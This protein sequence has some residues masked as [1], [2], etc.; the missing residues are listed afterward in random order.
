MRV[1]YAIIFSILCIILTVCT[2][3]AMQQRRSKAIGGAVAFFVCSLLPPVT[4]NLIIV[5]TQNRYV[6]EVG[7][8]VY[9]LGM[10][11]MVYSLLRLTFSYCR[12]SWHN[13]TVKYIV[14][15]L[16]AIDVLQYALNPYL[17]Q[18]FDTEP[19]IVENETYYK[20]VPFTGQLYHRILDY[21]V[22][23]FVLGVFFIKMIRSI[24][25]NRERYSVIFLSLVVGGVWE[26][27]YI[28]SGTPIDRSMIGFVVIG[29][30]VYY[31]ALFYRPMRL[32][33]SMLANMT[34]EL[35]E[36]LYFFDNN[37]LC[38]WANRPGTELAAIS[39][40]DYS[41]A[42]VKLTELFGELDLEKNEWTSNKTL[43][44]DEETRYYV[45][46]KHA[47]PY[48]D[49]K[50]AGS[51]LSIRDNTE[52]HLT[53]Q[54]EM[55]NATHDSLT[56]LYTKDYF[57]KKTE[58]LLKSDNDTH[59]VAVY[60]NVNN[61]KLI[62]D[63][64][65]TAFGDHCLKVIADKIREIA[66]EGCVYGR[67]VGDTFGMCIPADSFDDAEI[68]SALGHFKVSDGKVDHTVLIHIGIYFIPDKTIDVSL[69]FDRARM[70]VNTIKNDYQIFLSYYDEAMRN[71]VLWDQ[72][73]SSQLSEA[74]EERQ[75]VPY[76][77][78]IVNTDGKPVGAEALVRWIHPQLGFLSPA[79]F[80]P[81]FE[82]NGMIAE[83]D[84]YMWR[85]AC[86]ILA[87][88]KEEGKDLFISINISPKD[89]YFMDVVSVIKNY[90]DK[91]GVDH[92]RLRIEITES[93]MIDDN[94]YRMKILN[95]FRESGFIV[96]ID[97]F[98]SGYSSL[99]MLKDMPVDII[100]IDMGFLNQSQE[101]DRAAKILHNIINMN[102]DLGIISLTEGVETVEQYRM[103]SDMGCR[104]FQ[105]YHFAK[106]MPVEEFEGWVANS[107]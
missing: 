24:R 1:E 2:I 11:V 21:G 61:F 83:V 31:F 13:K 79:K 95:E 100:K 54:K 72:H 36:A 51:F 59:Y 98:G 38:I 7:Y 16:F 105:G 74:I 88:W 87:K 46:E 78:P 91:Y 23:F 17:R 102:S 35:P 20:L 6:A 93:V 97:D 80:V 76:L 60:A 106:P 5:C 50:D 64:F 85:S 103:L 62:N 48:S 99:N 52:E 96:E 41:K 18:A 30:L 101:N 12:I 32:L 89:F 43:K 75:I 90:T 56:D 65:G 34:S 104:L 3:T 37:G 49:K 55:H 27:F 86:E 57:L 82:K 73:I 58:E 15:S 77:Q 28:F 71:Q 47:I 26:T 92:S 39:E 53:L 14:Y 4:G 94:R 29:L 66:P 67:M 25:I 45:I 9:F 63:I 40:E 10:D 42:E 68:E 84:R 69:M 33:D 19:L 44:T 107:N 81:V 8:Y 22:F 70:A